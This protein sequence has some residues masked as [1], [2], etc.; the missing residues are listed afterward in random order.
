MWGSAPWLFPL[1]SLLNALKYIGRPLKAARPREEKFVS[2]LEVKTVMCGSSFCIKHGLVWCLQTHSDVSWD[3]TAALTDGHCV[4]TLFYPL[5]QSTH[6]VDSIQLFTLSVKR[7]NIKSTFYLTFLL[8]GGRSVVTAANQWR[9]LQRLQACVN[10][11]WISVFNTNKSII[12][13]DN[14]SSICFVFITHHIISLFLL[15]VEVVME[16]VVV[17]TRCVC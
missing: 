17:N 11:E 7:K 9:L 15:F 13:Y 16:T 8:F 1:I 5:S 2:R 4:H 12:C 6:T 10:W 14:I 3:F